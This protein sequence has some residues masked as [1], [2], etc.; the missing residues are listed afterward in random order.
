MPLSSGATRGSG[1]PR[2]LADSLPDEEIAS[3][4]V[5]L[6]GLQLD[7]VGPA[8]VTGHLVVGPAHLQPYG[9]VHGGVYA[10]IAESLA[11]IG[12]ALTAHQAGLGGAVGLENHTSFLRAARAGERIEAE[13]V[14]RHVGRRV[15]HWT[16]TMRAF[17]DGRELAVSTVRLLTVEPRGA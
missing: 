2:P 9:L 5:D 4:F 1:R 12:A 14:P 6:I 8:R 11:S 10:T 7:E 3:G 17:S 13:A 16:V 15:H